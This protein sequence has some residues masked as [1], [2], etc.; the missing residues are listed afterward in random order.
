MTES[1]PGFVDPS[2]HHRASHRARMHAEAHLKEETGG[3]AVLDH[4]LVSR[5]KPV[6][7]ENDVSLQEF[8]SHLRQSGSFAY[9][10]EFIGELTYVPK[11]CLI[12]VAT[13]ERIALID[14]LAEMDLLP[15]W[16]LIG[17]HTV[18]KIVHA[19]DQDVEPVIRMTGLAPANL[20]D[21][22]VL[23]GFAG[24]AYPASLQKLVAAMLNFKIGKGLTF[25][26]WDQRPLSAMQ[27]RY[28]ADD[29]R[30][31]PALAAELRKKT[32]AMNNLDFAIEEC[33]RRS[34]PAFF[35]ND[36]SELFLKIRGASNL[37][38]TQLA[39]LR[40]LCIWR[41]T[42]ARQQD[43]PTRALLRDDV[44]VGIVK[45][46]L[47]T[48]QDLSKVRGLPRPVAARFGSEIFAAVQKAYALPVDQR[49]VFVVNEE[50]ARQR[51]EIDSLWARLECECYDR[52]IDPA[53][54][55][56][57]QQIADLYWQRQTKQDAADHPLM[58]GWRGQIVSGMMQENKGSI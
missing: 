44:V 53:V 31:L 46:S 9:D 10:S 37:S 40:E 41:D 25:T 8:L 23:A 17:D 42:T 39:V 52:G 34:Q 28:A 13:M 26:H 51:F 24:L 57:R 2:R 55:A 15:F 21:T 29:V 1:K 50:G 20:I 35:H 5:Q 4:P 36:P 58:N 56:S 18:E 14:P 48:E 6:V 45:A 22:Q 7:V 12:Q 27:L 32:A 11:L 30:Y 38:R 43:I 3:H 33:K 16:Q 19:G 47:K 49:P 54:V